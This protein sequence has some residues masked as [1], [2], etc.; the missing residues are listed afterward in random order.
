MKENFI[1]NCKMAVFNRMVLANLSE[2]TIRQLDRYRPI[3]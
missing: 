1:E 2:G 3:A